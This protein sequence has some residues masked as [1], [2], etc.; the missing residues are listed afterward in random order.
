MDEP[1]AVRVIHRVT[2]AMS[3]IAGIGIVAL[4]LI[5]L[6]DISSRK[7][8][9][10]GISGAYEVTEIALCAVV[11]AGM[12]AA[13]AHKTHVR[14]PLVV[15][16]LPPRIADAARLVGLVVVIVGL[17]WM[18]YLTFTAGITSYRIGEYRFGLNQVPV[19][20]ARLFIPL[21]LLS[22]TLEFVADTVPIV[23]RLRGHAAPPAV[24]PTEA[25]I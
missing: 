5:A 16:R 10:P 22:L 3:L 19:W 11:F 8:V 12:A 7:F 2:S 24:T 1:R 25:V 17:A 4:M 9:G 15:E 20:P 21:G 14:T 23:Q 6:A 13:E 18:T